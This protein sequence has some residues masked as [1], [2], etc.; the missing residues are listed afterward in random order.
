MLKNAIFHAKFCYKFDEILLIA[1]RGAGA[2]KQAASHVHCAS[3]H[4]VAIKAAEVI[5]SFHLSF[6]PF[7]DF[8]DFAA[9]R[10]REFESGWRVE[11]LADSHRVASLRARHMSR[12]QE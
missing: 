9:C 4:F 1:R 3:L 5:P 12:R 2:V 11:T 10:R 8:S 6:M 7:G